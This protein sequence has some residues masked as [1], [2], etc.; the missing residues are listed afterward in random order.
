[1]WAGI[2]HDGHTTLMRVNGV[3]NVQIYQDAASRSTNWR[4]RWHLSAWQCQTPHCTSLPRFSPAKQR[5]CY[6]PARSADLSL[7]DHLWDILDRRVSQRNPPPQTL[8]IL[9]LRNEWQNIP[10]CTI[11]N[12][13]TCMRRRCAVVI[14]ARGWNNRYWTFWHPMIIQ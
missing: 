8:L 3:L 4:H 11:Q 6:W 7:T 5:S 13:V 10:Q 1:M 12:R 14:T 9:A 2:H